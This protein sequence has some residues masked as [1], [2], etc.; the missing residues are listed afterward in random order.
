MKNHFVS[1][2]CK[3]KSSERW[4]GLKNPVANQNYCDR[5][6]FKVNNMQISPLEKIIYDELKSL[7]VNFDFQK[8]FKDL[9][10][11]KTYV[12]DFYITE[13]KNFTLMNFQRN[14]I[15]KS[16]IFINLKI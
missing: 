3:S 15:K 5:K 13:K 9:K 2:L 4:K 10:N 1:D 12:A 11:N 16:L 6:D 7:D 14:L 8:V